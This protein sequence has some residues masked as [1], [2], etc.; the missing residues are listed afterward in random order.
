M[1]EMRIFDTKCEQPYLIPISRIV[2]AL[3][4]VDKS[5]TKGEWILY[6]GAYGYG[7]YV[8]A[9]EDALRNKDEVTV[10]GTELF[11]HIRKEIEYFYHVHLKKSGDSFEMG[12]FDSTYY[13]IR[14]LDKELLKKL[15]CFFKI[16]N[17][18]RI[19]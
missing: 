5:I 13:F 2:D 16:C 15:Q 17:I 8:C 3:D 6:S 12:L 9:L 11:K 1:Y 7:S 4:T 18:N 10:D 19:G 14:S